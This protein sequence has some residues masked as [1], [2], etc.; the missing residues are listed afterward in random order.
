MTG[1]KSFVSVIVSVGSWFA[2][3]S[4]TNKQ[5]FDQV[6]MRLISQCSSSS[7]FNVHI[8]SVL[9]KLLRYFDGT[10]IST[11]FKPLFI[12]SPVIFSLNLNKILLLLSA[13]KSIILLLSKAG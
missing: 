7:M 2:A 3:V 4:A 13:G 6:N 11:S 5:F 12:L 9:Q 10:I 8:S 1:T